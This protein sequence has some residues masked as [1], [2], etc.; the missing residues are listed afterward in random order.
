MQE[1]PEDNDEEDELYL[2]ISRL[3]Q[4]LNEFFEASGN[5][6][7]VWTEIIIKANRRNDIDTLTSVIALRD[8]VIS[9][10]AKKLELEERVELH[11]KEVKKW[12]EG[13]EKRVA[14]FEKENHD[15][16][17]LDAYEDQLMLELEALADIFRNI[18]RE[19]RTLK[20]EFFDL[21]AEIY[22]LRV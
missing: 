16:D 9:F 3:E 13:L 2:E 1:Y 14:A 20:E 4:E 15:E 19:G 7:P 8:K 10:I 22:K 5:A 17:A 18:C 11:V 21:N 6:Y 12:E